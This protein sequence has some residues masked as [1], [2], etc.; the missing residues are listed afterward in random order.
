MT[1]APDRLPTIFVVDDDPSVRT[2]LER[3]LRCFGWTVQTFASA[4]DF[5]E[6]DQSKAAGC[7]VVD[8]HLGRMSGIELQARLSER[9]IPLPVIFTSGFDDGDAE[10]EARRLGAAAFLRKPFEVDALLAAIAG[11]GVEGRNAPHQ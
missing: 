3:L 7:L 8:V 4:E 10:A 6:Q 5:L 9:R 1:N 2:G 11:A